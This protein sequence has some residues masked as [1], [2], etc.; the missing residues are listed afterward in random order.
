MGH[1]APR[2]SACRGKARSLT[3]G[4]GKGRPLASP[5]P[6]LPPAPPAAGQTF[7]GNSLRL[8]RYLSSRTGRTAGGAPGRREMP[9]PPWPLFSRRGLGRKRT[10]VPE[11]AGQTRKRD[12]SAAT[13]ANGARVGRAGLR[14]VVGGTDV[15][16][17][18]PAAQRGAPPAKMAP[19]P[20]AAALPPE[21][22]C[23]KAVRPRACAVQTGR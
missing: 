20:A 5:A 4:P 23:G 3:V 21:R 1:G 16:P 14:D 10:S 9:S 11:H 6:Y 17:P 12:A 13:G 15:S 22:G 8:G 18:Q 19:A 7:T 2:S